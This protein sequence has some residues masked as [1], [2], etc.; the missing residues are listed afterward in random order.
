MG[1]NSLC[2]C[3]PLVMTFEY[4]L[5]LIKKLSLFSE[6]LFSCCILTETC[7]Y[8]SKYHTFQFRKIKSPEFN[9]KKH[10]RPHHF[11]YYFV[12]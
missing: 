10:T 3:S 11:Y 12:S 7:E 4:E 5:Y 2:M 9:I 1:L 8:K 6:V